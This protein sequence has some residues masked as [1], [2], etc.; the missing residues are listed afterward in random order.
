MSVLVW[1]LIDSSFP[2]GGFAHSAGLEASAQHG[3][4]FDGAT[5]AAFAR[6]TLPQMGRAS[7]PLVTAAHRGTDT[8]ASVPTFPFNDVMNLNGLNSGY[9]GLGGVTEPMTVYYEAAFCVRCDTWCG[10]YVPP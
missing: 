4:V 7:L 5:V 9:N 10:A 3:L 2:S 8:L 1:Q 6:Q